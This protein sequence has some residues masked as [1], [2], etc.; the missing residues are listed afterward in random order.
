MIRAVLNYIII[1]LICTIFFASWSLDAYSADREITINLTNFSEKDYS[2]FIS[3]FLPLHG[4]TFNINHIQ[5]RNIANP[6]IGII[7]FYQGGSIIDKTIFCLNSNAFDNNGNSF[8]F[9]WDISKGFFF[10]NRKKEAFKFTTE[11]I[12]DSQESDINAAFAKKLLESN[13]IANVNPIFAAGNENI[14]GY[15]FNYVMQRSQTY[16]AVRTSAQI[17]LAIG[18]GMVQYFIMKDVNMVDWEYQ[19]SWNDAKRRVTDTWWWD[20]NMFNTNTL[21][22][23]YAGAAYYQI[24][25]SNNY[26][27]M[28]SFWWSFASSFVWEF[29]GE[30]RERVS[31]ND[32]VLTP[33]LGAVTGECLT[34]MAIFVERNM[35]RSFLRET[36]LVI[37]DPF[38][39]FNRALDSSNAGDMR[40][41]LIFANP[42]QTAVMNGVR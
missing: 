27:I 35:Q 20:P 31:G 18:G 11:M 10:N 17:L 30:W 9:E 12:F 6:T 37:L 36:I 7:N 3:P 14:T 16:L 5:A 1:L 21:Y 33:T 24:A 42:I 13:N 28:A 39:Y 34:Q 23:L 8:M 29:F 26:S 19:Y 2:R 40:V 22:H 32:V 41:R 38:R 4:Y 25:R 15:E